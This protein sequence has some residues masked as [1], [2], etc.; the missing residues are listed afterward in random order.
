MNRHLER[1]VHVDASPAA[2]FARL[3][4]QTLQDADTARETITER[5]YPRR[6]VWQTD[7]APQLPVM[8]GYSM[9][10][11][12]APENGGTELRVWIDYALPRQGAARFL[13][14][15]PAAVYARWRIDDLAQ[16]AADIFT[17]MSAAVA[18][19]P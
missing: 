14:P 10:Y 4:A 16:D 6:K 5:A 12:V 1:I 2:V 18:A 8:E 9:G 11:E 17:D 15:L 7:A 13:A 3:E 19:H